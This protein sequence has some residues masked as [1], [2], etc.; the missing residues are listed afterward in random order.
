MGKWLEH[1]SGD[2]YNATV[3]PRSIIRP[4]SRAERAALIAIELIKRAGGGRPPLLRLE[5]VYGEAPDLFV[6]V[7]EAEPA[8][9]A[10]R[11]LLDSVE[12]VPLQIGQGALD[13][14]AFEADVALGSAHDRLP[15]F[16]KQPI[17]V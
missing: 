6:E 15:N 17:I 1:G 10:P 8:A 2:G 12:A 3:D 13:V 11:G 4:L 5:E 14:A 16:I 7:D 9:L